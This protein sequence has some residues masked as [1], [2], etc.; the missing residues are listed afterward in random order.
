MKI[1]YYF[2]AAILL[3]SI[4]CR[5]NLPEFYFNGTVDRNINDCS[6]S[7]GYV[8]IINYTNQ[9]DKEDSLSTLTLPTQFKSSGAKI[10]FQMRDLNNT[11]ELMFCNALI[12]PPKQK[13]IYN[14]KSQ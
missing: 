2:F 12:V 10:K 14:I 3:S 11:D 7:S 1:V 13:V 6:G 9:N 8:F 4:S 5:K